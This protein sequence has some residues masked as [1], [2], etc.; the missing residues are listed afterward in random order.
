M[1]N[2]IEAENNSMAQIL[3]RLSVLQMIFTSLE[4]VNKV[5]KVSQETRSEDEVGSGAIN[6]VLP[7][8]EEQGSKCISLKPA[9]CADGE[10]ERR[11]LLDA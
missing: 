1:E 5:A 10:P 3:A 8:G 2:H 11:S 9:D 6:G 4:L 7:W